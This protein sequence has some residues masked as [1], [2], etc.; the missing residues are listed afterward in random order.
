MQRQRVKEKKKK[1]SSQQASA[2]KTAPPTGKNFEE[3]YNKKEKNRFSD[4]NQNWDKNAFF[5]WGKS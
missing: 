2:L 1:N 5:L 4:R 3:F